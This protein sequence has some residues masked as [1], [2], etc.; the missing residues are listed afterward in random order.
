MT[1]R[2]AEQRASIRQRF[3]AV[4]TANVADVLDDLGLTDQGLDPSFRPLSGTR[5]AGWA[6]T[7]QGQMQAYEGTGDPRK[8][9]ACGG[10][11]PDEISVWAGTGRGVCFF[12]ELIALG[13]AENGCVGA[14]VDGGVR[15]TKWLAEHE[16]PVFA[17]YS[18]PVQSIGRWEVTAWQ[19]PVRLPGATVAQV[20]VNPGD[21]VLAD[22]D[23]CIVVPDD[24]VDTVLAAAE[25]LTDTEVAVREAI[26]GGASLAA[27]LERFG[28]V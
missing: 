17:K 11:G 2:S 28:H 15:D 6:Y 10:I 13:M 20:R 16:F 18:T 1:G 25:K 12:G 7:I 14:L 9:S 8:M 3:L 22:E 5:L 21:F 19:E 4:D 27:C 23:G 26:A 24:Q